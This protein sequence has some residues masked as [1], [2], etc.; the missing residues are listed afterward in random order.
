M[1]IPIRKS[2]AGAVAETVINK[3]V[4]DLTALSETSSLSPRNFYS[5]PETN[6][7]AYAKD[8]TS[9]DLNS[10]IIFNGQSIPSPFSIEKII[11]DSGVIDFSISEIGDFYIYV[12]KGYVAKS[13][14][15]KLS[16]YT[17][18]TNMELGGI[19]ISLPSVYKTIHEI[20]FETLKSYDITDV[21][22]IPLIAENVTTSDS[23][24]IFVKCEKIPINSIIS[25]FTHHSLG[26][27]ETGYKVH[28]YFPIDVVFRPSSFSNFTNAVV[29]IN[30]TQVFIDNVSTGDL[31]V[32]HAIQYQTVV[33]H[34]ESPIAINDV[35][36]FQ[37]DLQPSF[38]A[39][40]NY[41]SAQLE[42]IPETTI[43]NISIYEPIPFS[44]ISAATNL[45]G[46]QITLTFSEL[47]AVPVDT[48]G[49]VWTLN[50]EPTDLLT[51]GILAPTLTWNF[52]ILGEMTNTDVMTLTYSDGNI[53]S[54]TGHIPLPNFTNRS[55]TNNVP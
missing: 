26:M 42:V 54:L 55:I 20:N 32:I 38:A 47:I 39:V 10:Y 28:V 35:V 27:D 48:T 52:D 24:R 22:Y 51:M 43:L 41:W 19:P 3:T 23:L 7:L 14:T 45:A 37:Y 9:L 49:L 30:N 31:K 13:I 1:A 29:K 34:L 15:F 46:N 21:N 8:N 53:T 36:T 33:L 16:E 18:I 44:I 4:E 2:L 50:G 17:A 5:I 25:T 11:I 12:P 40:K 6:Y